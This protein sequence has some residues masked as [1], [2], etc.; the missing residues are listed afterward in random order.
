MPQ[1]PPMTHTPRSIQRRAAE[2][3]TY[4]NQVQQCRA[5]MAGELL[6]N[7]ETPISEIA[8]QLG[9]RNQGNFT[10]AFHHWAKVSPS[11]FRKYRSLT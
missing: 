3:K 1:Q 8:D 4:S 7:S 9:Y 6:E 2:Q 5:E 10:R 11:E